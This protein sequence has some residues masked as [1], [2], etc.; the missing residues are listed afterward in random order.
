MPIYGHLTGT[1]DDRLVALSIA[2]AIFAAYE[3]MDIASQII[4]A[5]PSSKLAWLGGG[6]IAMGRN[7]R[8]SPIVH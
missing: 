8:E 6:S 3:A 5:K 1:Y 7:Q 2:I 4:I